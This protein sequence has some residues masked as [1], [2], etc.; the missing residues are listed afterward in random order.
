MPA[1]ALS[2]FAPA[3]WVGIGDNSVSVAWSLALPIAVGIHA[4]NAATP[5]VQYKIVATLAIHI[6]KCGDRSTCVRMLILALR[7]FRTTLSGR[8]ARSLQLTVGAAALRLDR[9]A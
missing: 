7:L 8:T 4:M 5:A 9:A 3:C 6:S 1:E 2:P